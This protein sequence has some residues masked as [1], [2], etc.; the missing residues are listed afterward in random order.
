MPLYFRGARLQATYPV[1]LVT[2]GQALNIT[3]HGYA[4][5]LA[6]GFTA[7]RDTLPRMQRLA[8]YSAEA[9]VELETAYAPKARRRAGGGAARRGAR[10]A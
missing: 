5:T 8:P 2:H 6:F 3:C 7:C 10:K 1:S 4:G 9:L